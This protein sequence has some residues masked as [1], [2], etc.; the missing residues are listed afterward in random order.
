M[1]E[2]DGE[3][4]AFKVITE[5]IGIVALFD[6]GDALFFLELVDGGELIAQAC[7]GFKLFLL[8]GGDHARGE[9]AF[10]FGMA[11]FKK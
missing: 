3:R 6:G 4:A 1:K 10:E 9:G 11:A 7:G 8:G 5:D 2:I